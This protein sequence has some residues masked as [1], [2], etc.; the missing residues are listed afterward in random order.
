MSS[1]DATFTTAKQD[2]DD[3]VVVYDIEFYTSTKEY[4]YEINA[5]TGAI[6][7]KDVET[8]KASS[9]GSSS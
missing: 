6:L 2:K 3:G 7:D 5:T 9:S 8:R 1:S 4:E